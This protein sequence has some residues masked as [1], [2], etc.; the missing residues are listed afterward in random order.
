MLANAVGLSAGSFGGYDNISLLA[1]LTDGTARTIEKENLSLSY[2]LENDFS[3]PALH[4]QAAVLLGAFTLREH[5]GDFYEIRSPLC[6]ITAHLA[7]ARYLGGG[8]LSDV[9]G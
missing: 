3:N 8:K 6:R 4:E 1:K 5:S 9:N 2:D 7:M